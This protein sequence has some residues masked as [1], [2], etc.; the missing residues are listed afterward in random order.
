MYI[1]AA[2][3]ID[4]RKRI[5]PFIHEHGFATV[6]TDH[7]GKLWASHLPVLFD[8]ASEGHGVLRSHMARAN[9]QWHHFQPGQEVLCIF[10]GPHS[11][12]SPS[13]Y[14]LQETV[15]TWNYAAVYAY[16]TAKVVEDRAVL[17]R[18]VDDTTMKYESNRAVPWKITLPAGAIAAML[19]AI[20]GFTIEITR[21]EAKFKLGQNKSQADQNG[22]LRDLQ[23][24]PHLGSQDLAKFILAQRTLAHSQP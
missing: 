17:R 13:S 16:G 24:S 15:P 12:I 10:H 23:A 21:V 14:V 9:E 11:Y 4:D 20:V 2:N 18:I 7:G 22:M 5:N 19:K 3:R 8:E 6:V 1:P